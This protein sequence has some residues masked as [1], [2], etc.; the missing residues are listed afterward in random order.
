[1]ALDQGY[2]VVVVLAGLKDDLRQQTARRFNAQLLGQ[3]DVIPWAKPAT[4]KG[5]PAGPGPLGGYAPS[6]ELDAHDVTGLHTQI[7][8][9][10]SRGKPA[11]IVVKK[12]G[13][14]LTA[15]RDALSFVYDKFGRPSV[16]TLVLD[17]ECDE[18]SVGAA[19]GEELPLPAGIA[20]L[21]R[22]DGEPPRVAYVGYTATAA[23]NIFQD[24]E[25]PLFPTDFA[26]MLRVPGEHDSITSYAEDDAT[27]WHTGGQAF[28]Q[29]F[30]DEPTEESD[31]LVAGHVD[32]DDV[33]ALAENASLEA[34]NIAYLVAGAYRLALVPG[35][36][37]GQPDAFPD[38]HS[39]LVHTSPNT[40]DHLAVAGHLCAWAGGTESQPGVWTMSGANI[41]AKV[42][43]DE[44]RWRSWYDRF[45]ASRERVALDRPRKGSQAVATW[46]QVRAL[47]PVVADNTRIKV[48]NSDK[49][50]RTL[51]F[52]PILKDGHLHQPPDC[53]TIAVGGAKLSRGLTIE[54]LCISYFLRWANAPQEDTIIQMSRWYGYRGPHLEFCRLFT[55]A[56]TLESLIEIHENDVELRQKV[57]ES[58]G[59]GETLA[60]MVLTIRATARGKPTGKLPAGTLVNIRFSPFAKVF[61]DVEC[62]PW[63]AGNEAQAR[64][65]V[66]R[67]RARS[68]VTARTANGSPRGEYSAGWTAE[69]VASLLDSLEYTGHN[70][71]LAGRPMAETHRPRRAGEP[72]SERMELH[73]D[74]YAAAAYLRLWAAGARAGKWPAPP[75]FNVGF[76]YGE[77]ATD[78]GPFDRPL[79][80]RTVGPDDRMLGGWTGR[81][82]GWAG[83]AA[84]DG[85]NPAFRFANSAKRRPGAPGLLLLHVIHKDGRGRRN[86][87]KPRASHTPTWGLII[88]EGGPPLRYAVKK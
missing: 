25:N 79:M 87:G 67:V 84:L 49:K 46:P 73:D 75:A 68:P 8:R 13:A 78:T 80:N 54:G 44:A 32:P 71:D 17:D 81:S 57:A 22:I 3:S 31:F 86:A 69:E 58:M 62:G 65:F 85:V 35:R 61:A 38:S 1:M 74:P 64:A 19:A 37:F 29:D 40:A 48:V 51:D 12:N 53:Y 7:S 60:E 30:G 77:L 14:S 21:W 24:S 41:A 10:L 63:Q 66:E 2:R 76:V 16:P 28:F 50:G 39:M 88:P 55:T 42:V 5:T 9:S 45:T 27:W 26:F 56:D 47:L 43:S 6:F 36:Q 11:V 15:L 4:T 83:D 20:N 34:A 33:G 18:A 82:G 52:N 23:A 59:R 70:P 72:A